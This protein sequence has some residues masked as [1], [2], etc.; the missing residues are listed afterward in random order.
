[1]LRLW[2]FQPSPA[3]TTEDDDVDDDDSL[4]ARFIISTEP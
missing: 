4:E 2:C 1:M 3:A